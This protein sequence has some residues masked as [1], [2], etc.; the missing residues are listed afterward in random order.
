MKQVLVVY[1][2]QSG[3]LEDIAKSIAQPFSDDEDV[4]LDFYEIRTV[5]SFPFPWR[6]D[7][8]FDIFPETFQQIPEEIHP[9]PQHILEKKYDL[10]LFHY[11]VW[12][13]T[14]SIPIN[15]FL[16]SPYAATILSGTP[17]VTVSGSRNMW[18]KAQDKV[19]ALLVQ[20]GARLVGNIALTDRHHNMISVVTIVDWLFSGIKRRAY[21]IFP[22]P[23]VAD[24]EIRGAFKY[25][26]TILSRV[27]E[28]NFTWMQESLLAQGAVDYRFFLVSMDK[29][30]NRMFQ[31]WSTLILKNPKKRKV[32]VNCFKYYVVFAI[33]FLSP[34]VF[35]IELLLLPILYFARIKKEKAHYQGI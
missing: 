22:L 26:E 35:L 30:A 34:I 21:G 17:V 32:L 14:P 7:V 16:K 2:S 12:Y 3:Q 19:K 6:G 5:H 4:K 23:G 13:L 1:Y 10:I 15:S 20:N 11:Q 9:P 25:G 24:Q 18:A 27:K 8:F 28:G 33:Y 29:K 31:I